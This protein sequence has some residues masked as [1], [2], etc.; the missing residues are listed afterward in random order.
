[1]PGQ[2]DGMQHTC[3]P[4][5]LQVVVTKYNLKSNYKKTFTKEIC[6]IFTVAAYT[7]SQLDYDKE[8]NELHNVHPKVR[9]YVL[10]I[11]PKKWARGHSPEKR[12]DMMTTNIAKNMNNCM[13]F[14]RRLPVTVEDK[15]PVTSLAAN[16]YNTE[17][18]R[19]AY[20]PPINLISHPSTWVV[21]EDVKSCIVIKR[22]EVKQAG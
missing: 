9:Q 16:W 8:M 5:H 20:A 13:K 11:G 22:E 3:S 14:A 7:Y 6:D 4:K 17:C 12:F 10:E 1:M 19:Q 21:L 2:V 15:C 18:I